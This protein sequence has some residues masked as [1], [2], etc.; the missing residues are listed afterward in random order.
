MA[1]EVY[2]TFQPVGSA[3]KVT[4]IDAKTGI[5]VVIMGPH[6]ASQSD[7]ERVALRKLQKRIAELDT[8]SS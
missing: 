4:A 1:N 6:T 2:F 8:P 7:L 3:V 5:E